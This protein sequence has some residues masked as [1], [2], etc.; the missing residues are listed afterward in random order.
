MKTNTSY[1]AC[2]AEVLQLLRQQSPV[3]L[4]RTPV[5]KDQ[6]RR[7]LNGQQNPSNFI[8]A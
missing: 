7:E 8:T 2:F 5:L 4:T 1:A 6:R 3:I